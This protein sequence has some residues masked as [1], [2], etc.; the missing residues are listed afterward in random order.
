MKL[1]TN[2]SRFI[3]KAGLFVFAVLLIAAS[4]P[5]QA[6][7]SAG[8]APALTAEQ[9]KYK[10]ARDKCRQRYDDEKIP[11]SQIHTFLSACMKDAGFKKAVH[12]PHPEL[13]PPQPSK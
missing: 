4:V 3:P 9:Q 7:T 13:T 5:L 12:L 10:T 11:R 2:I 6:K 1:A 8:A